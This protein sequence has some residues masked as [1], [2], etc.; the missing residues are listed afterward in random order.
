MG[1][2][3]KQKVTDTYEDVDGTTGKRA[4]S[5]D[6]RNVRARIYGRIIR[7]L[8]DHDA[9]RCVLPAINLYDQGCYA[10]ALEV[11]LEAAHSF[12]VISEEISP[13]IQVCRRVVAVPPNTE[14]MQYQELVQN[15]WKKPRLVRWLLE[16][17]ARGRAPT[18]QM[19]CKYCGH[20]TP[21]VDPNYGLAYL[22]G[23]NCVHC[24]RGYPMPDFAWDGLDG[25]AYIYYRGSVAEKSFYREFE[26]RLDVDPVMRVVDGKWVTKPRAQA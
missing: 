4:S 10:E 15:W 25:Q 14:D 7:Q 23:N 26:E 18:L 19:R 21:Y 2:E 17:F 9:N 24:E 11:F 1:D 3:A 6:F 16:R 13:H 12:P 22:G 8:G 5:R 20:Y